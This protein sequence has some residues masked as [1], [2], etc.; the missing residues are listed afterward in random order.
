MP[1]SIKR[2]KGQLSTSA[3]CLSRVPLSITRSAGDTQEMAI[4]SVNQ[5]WRFCDGAT[6]GGLKRILHLKKKEKE[7]KKQVKTNPSPAEKVYPRI[8]YAFIYARK[9]AA[10]V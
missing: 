8:S 6:D 1:A 9:A 2:G 7:K 5:N 4:L 3:A 10:S